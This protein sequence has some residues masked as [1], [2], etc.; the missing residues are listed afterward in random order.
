MTS[1]IEIF[2]DERIKK[3][4]EVIRE[5]IQGSY[6]QD[7]VFI[8]GGAIRNSLLGL[9][10]NDVDI[11][12]DTKDGGIGFATFIAFRHQCY[13]SSINPVVFPTY[14][15]AR[16]VLNKIEEIKDITI[17]CVET[18]KSK[19]EFGSL[20]D[21]AN[22]RDLTINSLM[23]NISRD[24]LMDF[25]EQG[26]DDLITSTLRT[27]NNP[28]EILEEDPIKILRIIR[29]STELGWGIE[30]DTWLAMIENA[31]LI[32]TVAQE[33]ISEEIAKILLCKTP[34]IGIRKMY[35]CGI[36][37]KVLPDIYDTTYAF[38]CKN[39]Q[40]STFEHTL[41]VLDSVQPRIETRLA[42]LFHDIGKIMT[43]KVKNANI[44]KFSA[45][46]AA[47]DLKKMKF[48]TKT[49]QAVETA[50]KY[51][52]AFSMYG[53]GIVPPDKK[54]RKFLNLVGENLISTFDLMNANNML[55]V[56]GN[57]KEQVLNILSRIEQLQ[58]DEKNMKVKLPITGKD[59]IKEFNIKE[60]KC[61]G[62]ILNNIKEAY[63]E[64]PNMTKDEAFEIAEAT[65]KK[66]V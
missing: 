29:F 34:S 39:K 51:H 53:K 22:R 66:I 38:E 62:I 4:V 59:I 16:V 14:N 56:K 45:D 28:S 33:R 43:P 63:F 25:T 36:L 60:G 27:P 41:D 7:H 10:V 23:Y 32:N 65:L 15:T 31:H 18:K 37:N 12:V 3:L 48:S 6:F 5:S 50:I 9:P 26:I 46:I 64:N 13:A 42:A 54:I 35:L 40:I 11:C 17:E 8:C 55:S 57:D 21:D 1:K 58:N 52:R 24:T 2:K 30:K 47:S 20:R 44:D 61:I 49:I 19:N